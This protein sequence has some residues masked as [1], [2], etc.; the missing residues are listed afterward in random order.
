MHAKRRPWIYLGV[1]LAG[2][3][4]LVVSVAWWLGWRRG[5]AHGW[6]LIELK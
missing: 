2:I 4:L 6:W 3:S 1:V 5:P